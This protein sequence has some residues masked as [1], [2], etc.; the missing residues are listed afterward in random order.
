MPADA[1]AQLDSVMDRIYQEQPQWWPHGLKRGLLDAGAWLIQKD[2]QPAGFVGLQVRTR[3]EG[4]VG[5]Y[6]VGVLPEFRGQGLAKKALQRMLAQSRDKIDSVRAMIVPG[7]TPSTKLA[8]SLNVPVDALTKHANAGL[9]RMLK[10]VAPSLTGGTAVAGINDAYLHNSGDAWDRK[11]FADLA[12]NFIFGGLAGQLGK[13]SVSRTARGAM[14]VDPKLL[15]AAASTGTVFPMLKPT[16]ARV[17]GMMDAKTK[18][19][20][21]PP[22]AGASGVAPETLMKLLGGGLLLGGGALGIKKIVDEMAARR[23]LEE[24]RSGGRVRVTLPTKNPGDGET[25][26][27]MPVASAPISN[28]LQGGINRDVLRRLRRE[29]TS[30]TYRHGAAPINAEAVYAE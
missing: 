26:I 25:Q 2:A 4:R 8:Q 18:A 14:K 1:A 3:P 12:Q 13:A 10:A 28:T 23:Q 11:R 24:T 16:A 29:V 27:D 17:P 22:A 20:L 21:T 19:M 7:N 6:S 30:R 9:L 15:T 5:Y